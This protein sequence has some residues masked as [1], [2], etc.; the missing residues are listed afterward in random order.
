M[1]SLIGGLILGALAWPVLVTV[2]GL[3]AVGPVTGGLFAGGLVDAPRL[4]GVVGGGC[5]DH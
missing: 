1:A 5:H 3:A 2:G 4:A